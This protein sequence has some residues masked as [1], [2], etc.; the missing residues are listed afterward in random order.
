MNSF[1]AQYISYINFL[2]L[3]V[4][5][6]FLIWKSIR[7]TSVQYDQTTILQLQE[8]VKA[9]DLTISDLQNQ[10]TAMQKQHSLEMIAMQKQH[11]LEMIAMNTRI[12]TINSQ[13]KSVE[14]A[15]QVLSNT[16]TGKEIL[17]DIQSS[18]L[19]FKPY[20]AAFDLFIENDKQVLRKMDSL[21]ARQAHVGDGDKRSTDK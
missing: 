15:N 13:M 9:R 12:E 5:S 16:V 8:A 7:S 6:F 20:A 4:G 10:I 19:T 1:I 2:A 17:A 3:A 18:L 21:L 14:Q 11:S